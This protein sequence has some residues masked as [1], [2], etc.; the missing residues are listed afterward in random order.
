MWL[1][2]LRSRLPVFP[3]LL[4]PGPVTPDRNPVRRRGVPVTL[5]KGKDW[6]TQL[7]GRNTKSSRIP[8]VHPLFR[9]CFVRP[10]LLHSF[11]E[12]E[13]VWVDTP[14][15]P[16]SIEW[17]FGCTRDRKDRHTHKPST[18]LRP[19]C[20]VTLPSRVGRRHRGHSERESMIPLSPVSLRRFLSVT[21]PPHGNRGNK[22]NSRCFIYG[23]KWASFSRVVV[24]HRTPGVLSRHPCF[25]P[26]TPTVEDDHL[27]LKFQLY[28][29][30]AKLINV[31]I[32]GTNSW[33]VHGLFTTHM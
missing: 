26:H 1:R 33:I 6:R 17:S 2:E 29:L 8:D 24:P 18:R 9:G 14:Q 19:S 27:T 32:D 28:P 5:G 12:F 11:N 25:K 13:W 10:G 7:R 30:Y 3:D 20:R 22:I 23:K 21:R 16:I 4:G 15:P 31:I